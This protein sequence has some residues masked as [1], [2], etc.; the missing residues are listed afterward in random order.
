M[1]SVSSRN[2]PAIKY[3]HHLFG[4]K[5]KTFWHSVFNP[6]LW[7]F[8]RWLPFQISVYQ[9]SFKIRPCHHRRPKRCLDSPGPSKLIAWR[10]SACPSTR[11]TVAKIP[12]TSLWHRKAFSLRS[13]MPPVV[14]SI[15]IV[16]RLR[17]IVQYFLSEFCVH[18]TGGEYELVIL[19]IV[20]LKACYEF[21]FP[22]LRHDFLRY[23]PVHR[24]K[25]T[26]EIKSTRCSNQ[27]QNGYPSS[28]LENNSTYCWAHWSTRPTRQFVAVITAPPHRT[29]HRQLLLSFNSVACCSTC[30]WYAL[31][32][33][34]PG[35]GP[36]QI[37]FIYCSFCAF[38]QEHTVRRCH[39]SNPKTHWLLLCDSQDRS[40][41]WRDFHRSS[42]WVMMAT[43]VSYVHKCHLLLI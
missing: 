27:S 1:W 36:Q 40:S 4:A 19:W 39:L 41:H 11:R 24:P 28:G 16:N 14:A 26:A 29:I 33:I 31:R 7:F 43:P 38:T 10:L 21:A 9:P 15:P 25:T 13:P 37:H 3:V 8:S 22:H 2:P 23:P 6:P 18:K 34:F 12:T 35:Y 32:S 42:V 5:L 30:S 17:K 20:P